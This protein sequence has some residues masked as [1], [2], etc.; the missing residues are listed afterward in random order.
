MRYDTMTI[1]LI[2]F[3]SLIGFIRVY[4]FANGCGL[5][6]ECELTL[7]GLMTM[8]SFIGKISLVYLLYYIWR[9]WKPNE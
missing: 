8:I 9:N 5:T 1:P 7:D 4:Q 6:L 3:A 2:I